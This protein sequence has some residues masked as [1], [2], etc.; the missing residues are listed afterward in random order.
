MKLVI[1]KNPE[2]RLMPEQLKQ[3]VGKGFVYHQSHQPFIKVKILVKNLET[4]PEVYVN[5]VEKRIYKINQLI[6]FLKKLEKTRN[7][8]AFVHGGAVADRQGRGYLLGARQDVGKTTLTLLLARNNGYSIIGD[9]A[10]DVSGDGYI[11][12]VQEKMGIFPHPENLRD[13]SLSLKEKIIAQIKY[14][15]FKNPPFCHLI[16]PNLRVDYKKLPQI[17]NKAELEKVFI[18]EKGDSKIFEIDKDTA[19]RKILS[20]SF[21]LILPEGFARRLFYTYCW[22]NNISPNFVEKE[23]ERI[24]NFAFEG[25]KIFLM[26]GESP[27]DFYNLFLKHEGKRL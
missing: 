5:K 21:D 12:R 23:Y 7:G 25:K 14:H 6:G 16:Y 17:K 2:K 26:K 1:E 11:Y 10:V 22:A 27:F 9:D 8:I 19:V 4:E 13:I 18:L 24:L 20:A 3:K 15:F